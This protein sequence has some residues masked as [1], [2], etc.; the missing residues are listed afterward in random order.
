MRMKHG[1]D[2]GP[3]ISVK[4]RLLAAFT[5]VAMMFATA[6]P[7][8]LPRTAWA[9]DHDEKITAN[10]GTC[11][12]KDIELGD[13]NVTAKVDN[14]VATWVGR[15]MYVGSRPSNTSVL[16]GWDAAP[17]GSYAAEAEGLTLVNGRLAMNPYKRSWSNNGFRFG[18]VGFGAQ[19]R[20]SRDRTRL[21]YQGRTLLSTAW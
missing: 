3:T 2:R 18:V 21:P 6:V 9:D 8:L 12:P 19:F 5:A 10:G 20:P 17:G 7:S 15:D 1:S 4:P 16:T 14:G 11:S 13:T